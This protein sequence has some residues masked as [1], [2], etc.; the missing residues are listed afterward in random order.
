[1][2][3]AMFQRKWFCGHSGPGK[4]S[5]ELLSIFTQKNCCDTKL[6]TVPLSVEKKQEFRVGNRITTPRYSWDMF[7]RVV[8]NRFRLHIELTEEAL[9]ELQSSSILGYTGS[10]IFHRRYSWM[11][12]IPASG[13]E[14]GFTVSCF[15]LGKT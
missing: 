3:G 10:H 8:W 14:E 13:L 5:Y 12:P 4:S 7:L 15:G 11:S 2:N 6:L 9:K 1:M